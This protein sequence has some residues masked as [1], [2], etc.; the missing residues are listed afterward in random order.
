MIESVSVHEV[1]VAGPNCLEMDFSTG[2]T[3]PLIMPRAFDLGAAHGLA[4]DVQR[5]LQALLTSA[6]TQKGLLPLPG[7]RLSARSKA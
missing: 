4:G 1:R 7:I 6:M 5:V 3:L 2:Q